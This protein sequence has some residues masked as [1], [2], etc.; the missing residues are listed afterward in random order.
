MAMQ[1]LAQWVEEQVTNILVK[2]FEEEILNEEEVQ[3]LAQFV[4]DRIDTLKTDDD[5]VNFAKQL[6]AKYDG[7]ANIEMLLK[8]MQERKL[9]QHVANKVLQLIKTGETKQA[10][11]LA[12]QHTQ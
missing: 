10:V 4:L 6:N 11:A 9:E 3:G 8:G 5:V 1:K 7:F 12:K 2:D